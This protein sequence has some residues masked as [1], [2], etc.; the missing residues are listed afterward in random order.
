MKLSHWLLPFTLLIPCLGLQAAPPEQ[1]LNLYGVDKAE[2]K[3]LPVEFVWPSQPGEAAICLW[4]DDK[5]AVI[6]Y[7]IDDN[8]A[9]NIEWWLKETAE[10]EM[11]VTWFLVAMNISVSNTV[12][13]GTWEGWLRVR[14]QGHAL[15]SHTMSHLSASKDMAT[16]KGIDWEYAESKKL[17]EENLP[18]SKVTCLTYA[19]GSQQHL[20][21]ESVAAKYYIAARGGRATLNPPQN[22]DYFSVRASTKP[23]LGEFPD[24]PHSN[25]DRMMQPGEDAYR[26]WA[27]LVYHFVQE[28]DPAIVSAFKGHLDYYV[29]HKDKLWCGRFNDVVRYAQ[30]RETATLTVTENT[31]GRIALSLTDR[32]MDEYFDFPLSIK[33]RL[34]DSWSTVQA[35][36]N[37]NPTAVRL[38]EHEG[39]KFA[40]VDVVPDKGLAVLTP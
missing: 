29:R 32:M 38:I 1:L 24:K 34:P 17:L 30:E 23:N 19:G 16:W 18:G 15:E 7:V 40:M 20:N 33:V 10:R 25:T 36:Q 35:T 26:G 9:Q 6:S 37:G 4:K 2:R 11:K 5:T 27:V 31:L 3:V 21:D 8:C 13:N 39:G 28:N 12:F 22:I 14:E